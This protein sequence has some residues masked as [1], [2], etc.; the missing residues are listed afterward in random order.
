MNNIT[1]ILRSS[2]YFWPYLSFYFF[3]EKRSYYNIFAGGDLVTFKLFH[4]T[5][6]VETIH[7]VGKVLVDHLIRMMTDLSRL[8]FFRFLRLHNSY[9]RTK[10]RL[11]DWKIVCYSSE[12]VSFFERI[13]KKSI[14]DR[15]SNLK[16]EEKKKTKKPWNLSGNGNIHIW[17]RWR[18]KIKRMCHSK[19]ESFNGVWIKFNSL[20]QNEWNDSNDWKKYLICLCS[21]I[22]HLD[23]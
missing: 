18:N 7:S 20:D 19:N 22:I 14:G 10:Q 23:P 15:F 1:I 16:F 2:F 4:S 17:L 12:N 11:Y 5:W 9:A 21:A 8:L 6:K 3:L 13:G